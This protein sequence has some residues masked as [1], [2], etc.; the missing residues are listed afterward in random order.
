MFEAIVGVPCVGTLIVEF[1]EVRHKCERFPSDMWERTSLWSWDW[2]IGQRDAGR[3][4][5]VLEDGK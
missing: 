2:T 5:A 3:Q 1:I 4:L